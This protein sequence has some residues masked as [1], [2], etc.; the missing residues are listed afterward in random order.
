MGQFFKFLFASCLG[1]LLAMFAIFFFGSMILAAIVSQADKP[2]DVKPNTVLHLT[3]DNPIPEKT[4]NLEMTPFDLKEREILGLN[5]I[6]RTLDNARED[7]N[8]KG[9]F[10]DV[11]ALTTSG[12]AT[13]T[14]LRS[15]L[16]QFRDSGKFIVAH[17]KYYTQGAYYLAS[18]A[19]KLYLNPVGMV[20]FR[21][22]AAQIPFFKNVLDKVGVDM[23]VFYA[24][25]FKSATEPYRRTEMSEE[26][27]LQTREFL[28]EIYSGFLNDI[29]TS[30]NV[31]VAALHRVADEYLGMDTDNAL[32]NGLVDGIAYYDEVL[33]DLRERLGLEQDEK[34]S[35]L[36]LEAYHRSN[37]PKTDYSSKNKI[38]VIYAEGAIVDG[39]GQN[40]SIG[41]ENYTKTI[42]RVREDDRVKA[43]VLRVNS[44]GGS[45]MASENIWRELQL[46]KE[47]GKPLIVSMGDYAA[48]GGYYIACLA[49]TIIAEPKTLTGSIGVFSMVPSAQE[50]LND[51]IGI[52]F[53]TVKT[54]QYAAGITPFYDLNAGERQIFQQQVNRIYQQFLTKVSEGR[55]MPRD[56]V[57][58][59]A[60]GRVWTGIR[61]KELG[62]VDAIGTLD[63]AVSMA[64]ATAGVED[65]RISEYPYIKDPLQQLLEDLMGLETPQTLTDK[66]MQSEFSEFYPYYKYAQ[67]IKNSKGMQARLPVMMGY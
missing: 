58:A 53:D 44:P 63:D 29:S 31:E 40:G 4:N 15:A 51:K 41:D 33:D 55:G 16:L 39:K 22:F 26:N 9:I 45:V 36:K 35:M 7:D 65:Y 47:A 5:E 43:V 49:D 12:F 20:D 52:N 60:Q 57:D 46:V 18:V 34:V 50:L 32:K 6:L 48:S 19:D 14:Q 42:R 56:S 27:K 64:A 21:G 3:F 59:I 37:P 10:L 61:A 11:D 23:Q 24:G 28:S 67:E 54:A 13:V 1:V 8:I 38:A 62:L 25:K 17:S 66:W 30:R 2:K